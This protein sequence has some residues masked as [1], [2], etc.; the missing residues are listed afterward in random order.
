MVQLNDEKQR[1]RRRRKRKRRRVELNDTDS[2]ISSTDG[3]DVS[4]QITSSPSGK[5]NNQEREASAATA[6]AAAKSKTARDLSFFNKD[7]KRRVLWT[8]EEEEMR[9]VGVE[10]FAAEVNKNM[11]WR[12][13]LEMGENVFS[14]TRTPSDLKDKWRNMIK[15]LH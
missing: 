10:K 15:A 9:K 8:P 3:E 4:E 6:V 11:P 12:K 13:I 5:M 7:Q 1:R 14:Q 2:D